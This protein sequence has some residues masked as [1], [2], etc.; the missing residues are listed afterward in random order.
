MKSY[1]LLF[2]LL[3]S[4]SSILKAE[5]ITVTFNRNYYPFEF[6]NT[7]GIPDGFTID[8]IYAVAEEAAL[9]VNLIEGNWKIRE[10]Q[11]FK[12]EIDLSP[13]YLAKTINSSV[14]HSKPL[15]NV[16]FS[17]LFL[18]SNTIQNKNDLK[19][20]TLVISSGDSSVMAISPE[21]Y[22][23]KVIRTKNW[24][25]S[26]KALSSGYGDYTI[27][28]TVHSEILER[29]YP[30]KTGILNNSAIKLPY[31]FYCSQWN[32]NML[33]KINNSISIIRASG[34]YD[35]IYRKWFADGKHL[36]NAESSSPGG[37]G[38][39]ITAFVILAVV[40]IIIKNRRKVKQ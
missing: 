37:I 6:I 15:F 28:S 23:D 14:N 3:I 16:Y 31:V 18:K 39:Y 22:S 29:E 13:G 33:D 32:R 2:L 10:D 12:G 20:R 11:L 8:L 4:I 5:E 19:S 25:D 26:V 35:R 30:D 27:I 40:L 1:I 9:T 7:D 24:H 34:E 21:N 36:I 38:M 17:F